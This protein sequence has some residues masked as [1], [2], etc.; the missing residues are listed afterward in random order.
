[1]YIPFSCVWVGICWI[2]LVRQ[3]L[4]NEPPKPKRRKPNREARV[5]SE[6]KAYQLESYSAEDENSL[7]AFVGSMHGIDDISG[8]IETLSDANCPP[9]SNQRNQLKLA[10]DSFWRNDLLN[11]YACACRYLAKKEGD[12]FAQSIVYT[13]TQSKSA[14]FR[15]AGKVEPPNTDLPVLK[16]WEVLGPVN[17]G[18]LE[19]DGDPT[20]ATQAGQSS[21]MD[22]GQYILSMPSNTTVLSELVARGQISF[23]SISAKESGEVRFHPALIPPLQF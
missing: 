9:C 12:G 17:V 3:I 18:K 14:V 6:V 13:L 8:K 11:A 16:K 2:V 15:V 4:S 21:G 23:R 22:V 10:I 5:R 19:I 1:M 20:F 7:V